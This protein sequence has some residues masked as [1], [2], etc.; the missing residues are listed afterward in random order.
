MEDSV[1]EA[2]VREASNVLISRFP[3]LRTNRFLSALKNRIKDEEQRDQWL[4]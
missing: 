3:Y 1:K 4:Q 2:G